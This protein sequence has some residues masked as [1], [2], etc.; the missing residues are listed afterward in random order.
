MFRKSSNFSSAKNNS[1]TP[2][3]SVQ[4]AY[5]PP[6]PIWYLRDAKALRRPRRVCNPT[7]QLKAGRPT[8][9]RYMHHEG[10][11]VILE[12]RLAN[13]S[14]ELT[15][16]LH[17][18]LSWKGCIPAKKAALRDQL[19][20]P[21]QAALCLLNFSSTDKTASVS[22]LQAPRFSATQHKPLLALYPA[23]LSAL[24]CIYEFSCGPVHFPSPS[25][26]SPSHMHTP[27]WAG[28]LT[29]GGQ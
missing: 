25:F 13:F 8:E 28:V 17:L 29:K 3:L 21:K 12:S 2:E 6:S 1:R 23:S 22:A 18:M 19:D 24:W 10:R 4:M 16:K 26:F 7:W 14:L 20:P 11:M 27:G 9:P 15:Q 5:G